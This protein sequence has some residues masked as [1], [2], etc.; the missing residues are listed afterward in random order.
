MLERYH[1][2]RKPFGRMSTLKY[3]V[4]WINLLPDTSR[5]IERRCTVRITFGYSWTAKTGGG[6]P[7]QRK[8]TR[9]RILKWNVKYK[10][11][12]L[13]ITPAWSQLKD[14]LLAT[15]IRWVRDYK[16]KISWVIFP[17]PSGRFRAVHTLKKCGNS[18]K[19]SESNTKDCDW[20]YFQTWRRELYVRRIH[21]SKNNLC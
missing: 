10:T 17:Y 12:F 7:E 20:S 1:H 4:Y 16:L 9:A 18:F 13:F 11:T 21:Q 19:R 3:N 2:L 15:I 14:A 5:L 6:Y 8:E